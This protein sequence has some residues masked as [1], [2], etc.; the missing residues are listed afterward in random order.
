MLKHQPLLGVKKAVVK[1]APN[2]QT[3][4]RAGR[5]AS[6]MMQSQQWL[7]QRRVDMRR[8]WSRPLPRSPK[9]QR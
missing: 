2:L 4:T 3:Q 6:R 1:A 8:L 7:G 9:A 5:A